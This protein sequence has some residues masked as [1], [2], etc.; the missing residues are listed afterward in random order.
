[1][2]F[3]KKNHNFNKKIKVMSKKIFLTILTVFVITITNAQETITT[4][5][6]DAIRINGTVNY[7]IRQIRY[8][9]NITSSSVSLGVR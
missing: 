1:M 5:G 4:I 8:T 2:S 7:S 3:S 6:N 9:T